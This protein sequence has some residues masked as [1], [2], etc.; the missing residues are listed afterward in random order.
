MVWKYFTIDTVLWLKE[1]KTKSSIE[2]L[3][4]D[5]YWNLVIQAQTYLVKELMTFKD[6]L[7]INIPLHIFK[8]YLIYNSTL[9]INI[10]IYFMSL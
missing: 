2:K 10:N 7:E 8:L 3:P 4:F 6:I 9:A 5:I 1:C